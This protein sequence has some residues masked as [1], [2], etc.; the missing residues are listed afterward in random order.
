MG[1]TT[2]SGNRPRNLGQWGGGSIYIY[3]PSQGKGPCFSKASW[4]QRPRLTVEDDERPSCGE[5]RF[6]LRE[7]LGERAQIL[8]SS[9]YYLGCRSQGPTLE[10]PWCFREHGSFNQPP[11]GIPQPLQ[12]V[13]LCALLMRDFCGPRRAAGCKAARAHDGRRQ[14]IDH[15]KTRDQK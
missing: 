4:R 7:T 2:I 5:R 1:S 13:G 10:Q 6:G 14:Y 15:Q 9:R 3:I 8:E 12:I 11:V